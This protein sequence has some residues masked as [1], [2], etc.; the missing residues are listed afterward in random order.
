MTK[1]VLVAAFLVAM[2]AMIVAVDVMVFRHQFWERPIVNI[3][4]VLVFVVFYL[5]FLKG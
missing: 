5:V 3:S 2:V 4:I 1:P